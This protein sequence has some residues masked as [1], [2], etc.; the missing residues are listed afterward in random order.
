MPVVG[1]EWHD[2]GFPAEWLKAEP[3][4]RG[5]LRLVRREPR[6]VED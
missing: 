3:T 2:L 1:R 5:T 4:R 6:S